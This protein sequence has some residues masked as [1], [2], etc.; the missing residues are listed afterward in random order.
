VAKPDGRAGEPYRCEV[1]HGV[2]TRPRSDEEAE[3]ERRAT[4]VEPYDTDDP[5]F[6]CDDC[7]AQVMAWAQLDAPELLRKPRA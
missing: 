4:W 3:I 5:A 1:C 7:F 2:F 6:V